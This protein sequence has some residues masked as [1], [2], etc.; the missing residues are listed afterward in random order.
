MCFFLPVLESQL[1]PLFNPKQIKLPDSPTISFP[2]QPTI[3]NKNYFLI[4]F[5]KKNEKNKYYL[6]CAC[7][8]ERG[9]ESGICLSTKWFPVHP[10][11]QRTQH[12]HTSANLIYVCRSLKSGEKNC[13]S[14]LLFENALR[15][16]VLW[17]RE[18]VKFCDT[19]LHQENL[20]NII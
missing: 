13:I 10:K 4:L 9:R 7:I 20:E 14:S 8:T 1:I 17:K 18:I 11:E 3:T 19:A 5:Q 16:I 2:D 15:G 6:Y 12:T